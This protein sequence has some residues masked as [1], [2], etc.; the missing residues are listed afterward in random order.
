M[1]DTP[2]GVLWAEKDRRQLEIQHR[3][4]QP[5]KRPN[6]EKLGR[7][8]PFSCNWSTLAGCTEHGYYVCR[9]NTVLKS[10]A[11]A[12]QREGGNTC[13][14]PNV[15]SGCLVAVEVKMNSR[16]VPRR[17]AEVRSLHDAA[18]LG[19]VVSGKFSYSLGKGRGLAYVLAD[20]LASNRLVDVRLPNVNI[21]KSASLSVIL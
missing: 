5:A 15:P 4:Y 17:F 20:K 3:R 6:Y 9:E 1:L 11:T 19:Y 13:S 8:L 18:V 7:S 12:M 10:L 2:A 14:E 16:G 21:S